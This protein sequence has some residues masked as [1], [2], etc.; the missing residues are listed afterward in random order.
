MPSTT[1]AERLVLPT[2]ARLAGIERVWL[3]AGAGWSGPAAYEIDMS[4]CRFVELA[5]LVYIVAR[6]AERRPGH[7]PTALRLP[8]DP[9]VRRF[10]RDVGFPG[11][12]K[13][14]LNISFSALVRGEHGPVVDDEMDS[15]PVGQAPAPAPSGR[16]PIETLLAG[17]HGFGDAPVAEQVRRWQDPGLRDRLDRDVPGGQG[18]LVATAVVRPAMRT[19]VRHPR[20]RI[21]QVAAQYGYRER[22]RRYLVLVF[23]DDGCRDDG[24]CCDGRR[25]DGCRDDGLPPELHRDFVVRLCDPRGSTVG[26][27]QFSSADPDR[28]LA[29]HPELVVLAGV[30]PRACGVGSAWRELADTV[31]DVFGGR[32]TLRTG[33][34]GVDLVAEPTGHGRGLPPVHATVTRYPPATGAIR[35]NLLVVRIPVDGDRSR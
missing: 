31:L 16:F 27:V 13:D 18:G 34:L 2:D 17:G 19:L 5:G 4:G 1:D 8:V 35:G 32:L 21:G 30:L 24:L 15:G 11:A 29:E 33:H 12:V 3:D 26:R 22:D 10:L 9:R 25:D 23:W 28:A 14:A 20:A 6:L 7:R